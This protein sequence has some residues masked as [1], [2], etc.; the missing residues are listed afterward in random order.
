MVKA[1]SFVGMKTAMY[2]ELEFIT[3]MD[4][5]LIFMACLKHECSGRDHKGPLKEG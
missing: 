3:I 4:I 2:Y 1:F 5:M